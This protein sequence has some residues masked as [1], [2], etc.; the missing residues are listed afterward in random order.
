MKVRHVPCQAAAENA[1][2][3][4]KSWIYR[5]EVENDG[6]QPIR[7]VWFD[8]FFKNEECHG[9]D[10]FGTNIRNR[11]LRNADFIEWYGDAGEIENGWIKPGQVA[12]CDPNYSFAFGDEITPVKWSF[13]AV[14]SDGN[15]YFDEAIV[16]QDAATLYDPAQD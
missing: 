4:Q 16:P 1:S 10:W 13:I 6:D 8:F 5:T 3:K 15:D 14:D 11:P 9:G 2:A 12:V 7:V